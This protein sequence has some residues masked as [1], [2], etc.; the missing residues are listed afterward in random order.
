MR[1]WAINAPTR[2]DRCFKMVRKATSKL[3]AAIVPHPYAKII[4][5]TVAEDATTIAT[6]SYR[7]AGTDQTFDAAEA[8]GLLRSARNDVLCVRGVIGARGGE[9]IA[10]GG[11]RV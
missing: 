11:N 4:C 5:A 6:N 1:G 9:A 2:R 7:L 8:T 3:E 10:R